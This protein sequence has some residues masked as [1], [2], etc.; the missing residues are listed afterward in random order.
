MPLRRGEPRIAG[1]DHAGKVRLLAEFQRPPSFVC[2]SSGERGEGDAII[3]SL[4]FI[5]FLLPVGRDDQQRPALGL[6]AMEETRDQDLCGLIAGQPLRIVEQDDRRQALALIFPGV[7]Q[8]AE[9][10]E[11]DI[12]KGVALAIGLRPG[13]VS[14]KRAM[15][16]A[17]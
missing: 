7:E 9:I 5:P 15:V 14:I 1:S 8:R 2:K 6:R 16:F 3:G 17:D 11:H 10:G 13:G 12:H 4:V